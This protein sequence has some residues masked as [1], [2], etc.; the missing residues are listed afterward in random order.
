MCVNSAKK[1]KSQALPNCAQSG[2][3]GFPFH[4]S[5]GAPAAPCLWQHLLLPLHFVIPIDV[6]WSLFIVFNCMFLTVD[7]IEH[8]FICLV[9]THVFFGE[10][11]L[12]SPY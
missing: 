5:R 6:W 12:F 3:T 11:F 8:L 10:T 2:C 9:A 7:N 4:S 1:Q